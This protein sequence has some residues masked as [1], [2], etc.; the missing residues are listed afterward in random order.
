M[1]LTADGLIFHKI[2]A[3]D[4]IETIPRWL[5]GPYHFPE[6]GTSRGPNLPQIVSISSVAYTLP[7]F[8]RYNKV[9]LGTSAFSQT[10]ARLPELNPV[11]GPQGFPKEL[12]PRG[13]PC[14]VVRIFEECRFYGKSPHQLLRSF[15]ITHIKAECVLQ[16]EERGISNLGGY[17]GHTISING[18]NR[19]RKRLTRLG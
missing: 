18:T 11:S 19:Y 4:D 1:T 8:W 12:T 14:C 10:S 7:K 6:C 5:C 13:K 17:F 3:T 16:M 15:E 9:N 2:C